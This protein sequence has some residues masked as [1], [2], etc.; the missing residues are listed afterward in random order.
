M[1]ADGLTIF[2]LFNVEN[3]L[4]GTLAFYLQLSQNE[5]RVYQELLKISLKLYG[6]GRYYGLKSPEGSPILTINRMRLA[7]ACEMSVPTLRKSIESLKANGVVMEYKRVMGN[8]SGLALLVQGIFHSLSSAKRNSM[9][10]KIFPFRE[11]S[12]LFPY[13]LLKNNKYLK[14]INNLEDIEYYTGWNC[15]PSMAQH[16]IV[17]SSPIV[18]K[19]GTDGEVSYGKYENYSDSAIIGDSN[20]STIENSI[21]IRTPIVR[22]PVILRTPILMRTP[23]ILRTP[24]LKGSKEHSD[25]K[26]KK[27]L[28]ICHGRVNNLYSLRDVKVMDIANY[29]CM[30]ARRKTG[31]TSYHVFNPKN[32]KNSK[33]WVFFERLYDLCVKNQ[34]D[35][36]V[37]LESQFDRAVFWKDSK[38]PYVNALTSESAQRYFLNY[39]KDTVESSPDLAYGGKKLTGK[40]FQTLEQEIVSALQA[41]SKLID[42][43]M[44]SF[45]LRQKNHRNMEIRNMSDSDALSD[46]LDRNW[47]SLSVYYLAMIERIDEIMDYWESKGDTSVEDKRNSL[48]NI[49]KNKRVM[50]VIKNEFGKIKI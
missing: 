32:P 29:Y 11:K 17:E 47:R 35:Y 36:Q 33:N 34:W 18:L 26:S 2:D 24:I 49:R 5:N 1:L 46:Y 43:Y 41:D 25:Y 27:L 28:E 30:L 23:V 6:S 38:V 14:G 39:V 15:V 20:V 21:I 31:R 7:G 16:H 10:R 42:Y 44:K 12:F 22:T 4:G 48:E 37:Y 13:G 9:E 3:T 50:G 40:E 19:N 45:K 8:R